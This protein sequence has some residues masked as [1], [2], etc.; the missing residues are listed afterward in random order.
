MNKVNQRTIYLANAAV[1]DLDQ[2][3]VDQWRKCAVIQVM[4]RFILV[5]TPQVEGAQ[6]K[7]WLVFGR[8]FQ[9]KLARLGRAISPVFTESFFLY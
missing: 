8:N 7:T 6:E 5:P 1:V 9:G 4:F 2:R 3:P